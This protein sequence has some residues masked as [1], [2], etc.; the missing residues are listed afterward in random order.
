MT[1]DLDTSYHPQIVQFLKD[2]GLPHEDVGLANWFSL[3]GIEENSELVGIAGLENCGEFLLLRSVVI[4]E[5]YRGKG[6]SRILINELHQRATNS[7]YSET[8]L[9]TLDKAQLFQQKFG[10]EEL[11]RSVAPRPI[12]ES[13][14]FSGLCPGS[15]TL[16]VKNLE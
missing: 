6:L 15:A 1:I 5:S 3:I 12:A 8:Y 7:N 9:L 11:E 13:R 10:Y 14:Q 4:S 16:M 2:E